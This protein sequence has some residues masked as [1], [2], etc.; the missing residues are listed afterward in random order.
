M[1]LLCLLGCV[2]LSL[3]V[4]RVRADDTWTLT[5]AD[6]QQAEVTLKTFDS[7]GV[8]V[9]PSNG[10]EV[11]A[12]PASK[13]LRLERR[14][15]AVLRRGL[16]LAT[17]GGDRYVGVPKHLDGETL[18][19]T[20]DSVGDV[21][22]PLADVSAVL[23]VAAGGKS[24]A[25]PTADART[26]DTVR[27]LNGDTV[28]GILNGID[29][30]TVAIQPSTGDA[31]V[32]PIDSVAAVF[33][34][35][36]AAPVTAS[37]AR[38]FRVALV[39][40][41]AVSCSAVT[42]DAD[43]LQLTPV[44]GPNAKVPVQQVVAIEQ[45]NGPIAWLSDRTPVESKQIPFLDVAFPARMDRTVDGNPITFGSHA[46]AHGIGV[47][48]RSIL[49][50]NVQLGDKTFRTRFAVDGDAPYADLAVRIKLDDKV[51]FEQPS[52]RAG[53][54]SDVVT[55]ELGDAKTITLEADYGKGYDVQDRLN[56]IEP[57]L[58]RNPAE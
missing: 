32:V 46:Y 41:S 39:D 8:S 23:R 58:L 56:W 48:S 14:T 6:F 33:L 20:C 55:I 9:I 52:V 38:A 5:T 21:R 18:V 43:A 50:F 25:E 35:S 53:T 3:A 22:V 7:Q 12:V 11:K 36:T 1:R 24:P 40:G 34:A 17:R 31:A 28:A 57:A 29:G 16:M 44:A 42:F 19:W 37:A 30:K 51:M 10:S 15:N 45:I 27:L 54:L 2:L 26:Q 4:A 47:H 13:L 49:T